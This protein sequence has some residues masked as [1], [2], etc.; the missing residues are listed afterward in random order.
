MKTKKG[1]YSFLAIVV[2]SLF[3]STSRIHADDKVFSLAIDEFKPY[4]WT[5]NTDNKIKG[6]F[7]DMCEEILHKR[8]GY[9]V[10]YHV[11]P[12]KRAQETVKNGTHDAFITF[13]TAERLN[14][15]VEGNEGFANVQRKMFTGSKNPK[16]NE[17]KKVKEIKDL[18]GFRILGYAGDGW[19]KQKLE[20]EAGLKRHLVNSIPSVLKMLV[21][22]RGDVFVSSPPIVYY[23]LKQL[24]LLGQVVELP[25]VFE[26]ASF[27]LLISKNSDLRKELPHIDKVLIEMRADGTMDKIMNKWR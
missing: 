16:I 12:W 9:K 14:Y 1:I 17:L 5:D 2:F 22:N 6:L 13:P 25:V 4:H 19:G 15:T 3:I 24:G 27:K 21:E 10:E 20:I 18:R 11:Y 8:L 7:I 26:E 23:E